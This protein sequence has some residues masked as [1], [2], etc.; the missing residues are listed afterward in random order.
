MREVEKR[1]GIIRQF[2]GCFSDFR[3]PEWIEHTVAELVGQ[4][5]YGLALG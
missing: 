4:R 1:T 2:A 3:K 5:V